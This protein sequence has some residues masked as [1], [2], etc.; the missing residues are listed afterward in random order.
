MCEV[1]RVAVVG[2]GIVGASV[3][4]HAARAGASVTVVDRALPGSGAT[5]QSFAWIGGPSGRDV[6]DGST[7]VRESAV[8]DYHRLESELPDLQVRWTGSLTWDEDGRVAD[9]ALGPDERLLD[10]AQ[11]GHLEPH[12][13]LP[14]PFALHKTADGA[15]DPVAAIDALVRGA[16]DHGAMVMP[17]VTVAGLR[18]HGGRVTG[19]DTSAGPVP[20]DVVVLAAGVDVPALCRPLSVDLPV[21]SSPAVL[22][23]LAAPPGLVHTVVS[24]PGMDV[25]E[26]AVGQLVVV[27]DHHGEVTRGDLTR[28]AGQARDRV[29]ALFTD[30]DRVRVTGRGVGTRPMPADGMPV[31]GPLPDISGAYV[32]VMHSAVSLAA[33]TGRLVAA[34]VVDGLHAD[35]LLD[36]RPERF[37]GGSGSAGYP[38]C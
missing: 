35:E 25:R 37:L 12:L 15:V 5:G 18:R 36:L 16:R 29:A 31:V 30:G 7:P 11:V 10:A 14:P 20:A 21:A 22:V 2:A 1:V 24:S 13:R 6:P 8:K 38:L 33:V 17:R 32:A 9:G 34:E 4:Y 28:A 19:V 23:R 3:A 26:A 27:A